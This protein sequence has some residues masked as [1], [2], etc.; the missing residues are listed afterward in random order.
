LHGEYQKLNDEWQLCRCWLDEAEIFLEIGDLDETLRAAREAGRLARKLAL[1]LEIGRA[2]LLEAAAQLRLDNAAIAIPLL[3]EATRRLEK[4]G[5]D[6]WSAAARL[7][8]ALLLGEGGHKSALSEAAAVRD[9]LGKAGLSHRLAMADIVMGRIHRA[10]GYRELAV[11]TFRSA[12]A[13][14]RSS[15]SQWMQFHACYELGVSL[16]DTQVEEGTTLLSES[17]QM[18]DS[19]WGSLGSDDLKMA[20][21]ADRENVY[22]YLVRSERNS[23]ETAFELSEKARSRVLREQLV[24]PALPRSCTAIQSRLRSDETIVEYFVIGDDVGIFAVDRDSVEFKV[25]RGIVPI[26]R[27]TCVELDRHLSS[28]SV[29]WEMLRPV[30]HHLEATAREHLS[31][32]Y[33]ELIGPVQETLRKTVVIVPHGFLHTVPFH[34]L[35]DGKRYLSDTHSVVY[36]PS[37]LLYSVPPPHVDYNEPLFIAFSGQSGSSLCEVD[38][39]ARNFA[40]AIVLIDPT[41]GELRSALS[42]AHSLVHI[43]GHAG[44]DSV[45]GRIS[46][47]ETPEGRLTGPDLTNMQIC[48]KTIVVTGCQTARRVIRPGD[49]WLGLMRAF[50]SSGATA[51]VSAFWEIRD[52][53]A[54]RFASEFYKHFN[55]NNAHAAVQTAAS[56][57]KGWQRHPYFWAGFGAFVRRDS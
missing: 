35:F 47:I 49:E 39:V 52:E 17:E 32:F 27:S 25:S 19:L 26:L 10:M 14:A 3:Q 28:C 40:R 37:A 23:P 50:Y 6:T 46:W 2:L 11:E 56:A 30:H 9:L 8:T 48:A 42:T 13:S 16:L 21:L 12:L 22:T 57:L 51:I 24:D 31:L 45:G 41:P 1:D 54:R 38:E 4:E 34:G 7:Q 5:H 55:G 43:A 36:S 29:K 44:I 53:A 20:F 33:K 15:R 18:L